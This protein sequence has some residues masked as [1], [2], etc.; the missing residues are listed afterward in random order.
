MGADSEAVAAVARR[1]IIEHA[2]RANVG[3]IGSA[4]CVADALAVLYVDGLRSEEGDDRDRF[5]L[6]KGHAA[7][8]LYAT[9][10][11]TGRLPERHLGAYC[12]NDSLFGTHPD[13]EAPAVDFTTGSLGQGLSLAAGAAL[14]ARLDG[15]GRRTFALLS[16]AECDEGATWEAALWA[17]HQRLESLVVVVDANGQQALGHTDAVLDLEPLASKWESFRWDVTEVDGHDHD[18]LHK[19]IGAPG[20]G[21]PRVVI[22]RTVFGRGVSFMEG[23]IEWHYLPLDEESYR[24]ALA[25]VAA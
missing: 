24:R 12:G 3:H 22:A 11:A 18:A 9:L 15:S 7:L 14:A 19:A 20:R 1:L 6:S 5:V 2:H 13:H 25:E 4:L 16:D 21:R 17:G 8:A 10:V 23:R